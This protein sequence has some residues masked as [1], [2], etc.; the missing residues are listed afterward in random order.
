MLEHV[1]FVQPFRIEDGAL[2]L[3]QR[4]ENRAL[5][6]AEFRRVEPH[7]PQPLH[8]QPLAFEAGRQSQRLHVLR[9]AARLAQR[10]H[11]PAARGFAA[12]VDAAFGDRL[13]GDARQRFE[14]AGVELA[15][16]IGNPR[17][18]ALAGAVVGRRH[19]DAGAD[20]LLAHQLV[21]VAAG[22]ALELF[23]GVARRIDL[24]GALRAAERHVHQ[25]ALVG[26]QRGQRLHFG[27]IHVRA[28]ADAAF[29]G[30]LVMAVLGA[31]GVDHFNRPVRKPHRERER[32]DRVA[33][34]DLIE[35]AFGVLAEDGRVIEIR[36]DVVFKI[37]PFR[38]LGTRQS[39]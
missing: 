4:D 19:V 1:F 10:E 29:G 22:D 18:L 35:E 38:G 23:H 25:R 9:A 27:F 11:Q 12:A 34:A 30:Q 21:G 16:G 31:P 39:R 5:L 3:R 17:H 37:A 14:L 20:E 8:H 6:A 24:H 15:V 33:H 36:V 7:I 2:A 32:V 26:H 28:E 13:S